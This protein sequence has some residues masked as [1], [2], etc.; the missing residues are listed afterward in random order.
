MVLPTTPDPLIATVI[1]NVEPRARPF[2]R[3]PNSTPGLIMLCITSLA[4]LGASSPTSGFDWQAAKN[5][6]ITAIYHYSKFVSSPDFLNNLNPFL[7]VAPFNKLLAARYPIATSTPPAWRWNIGTTMSNELR[8]GL[9]TAL[10]AFFPDEDASQYPVA[11]TNLGKI[12]VRPSLNSGLFP[13]FT[14]TANFQPFSATTPRAVIRRWAQ[15]WT[16][17]VGPKAGTV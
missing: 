5:H 10:V 3:V 14:A 12:L 11:Q 9:Q 7:P 1:G 6:Q 2:P 8:F 13:G 4:R 16:I 17:I 15:F